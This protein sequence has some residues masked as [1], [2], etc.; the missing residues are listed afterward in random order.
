MKVKD[1][2]KINPFQTAEKVYTVVILHE[3]GV[4]LDTAIN[5][6]AEFMGIKNEAFAVALF[7]ALVRFQDHQEGFLEAFFEAYTS[8]GYMLSAVDEAILKAEKL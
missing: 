2:V 1:L 4:S 6:K 5:S 7:N 8:S 3:E